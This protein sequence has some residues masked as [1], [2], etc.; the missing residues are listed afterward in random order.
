M[1][2]VTSNQPD[3]TPTWIELGVPDLERAMEFYRA[4]FGWEYEV[5][6][7]EHQYATMCLLRGRPVAGLLVPP[8]DPDAAGS[9]WTVYLAA[10]DCEGTAGRIT[11]AGGTLVQAPVD[12]GAQGR[13]AIATDPDRDH[14]RSLRHG[15]L[16]DHPTGGRA[17]LIRRPR[18]YS[19][20][21]CCRGSSPPIRQME[22]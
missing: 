20:P 16:D 18:C 6:P 22:Y 21:L 7:A 19:S 14:H 8:P 17:A 9:S 2:H 5:G 3:G 1:S 12:V 15:V 4:L 11:A 10:D 13:M